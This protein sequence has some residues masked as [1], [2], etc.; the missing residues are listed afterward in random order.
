MKAFETGHISNSSPDLA[1]SEWQ[2]WSQYILVQRISVIDD[3]FWGNLHRTGF[4]A[5]HHMVCSAFLCASASYWQNICTFDQPVFNEIDESIFK[6]AVG[7]NPFFFFSYYYHKPDTKKIVVVGNFHWAAPYLFLFPT[8]LKTDL[9]IFFNKNFSK[10]FS[11]KAGI[12]SCNWVRDIWF[13]ISGLEILI[14]MIWPCS[15]SL[16]TMWDATIPIPTLC[17]IAEIIAW[18][19]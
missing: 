6:W 9:F 10:N 7:N 16:L 15:I 18:W 12:L 17:W 8:D 11:V 13:L 19:L 5:D 14:P 4:P 2:R 1:S 3:F